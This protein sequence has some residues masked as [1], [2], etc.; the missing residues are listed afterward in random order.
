MRCVPRPLQHG[1]AVLGTAGLLLA[2]WPAGAQV[3]R[4]TDPA[5]GQVSYTNGQCT[6]GQRSQEI[7]PAQSAG[8]IASERRQ[9]QEARERW[10]ASQAK[11]RQAEQASQ[12]AARSQA[13]RTQAPARSESAACRQAQQALQATVRQGSS[14]DADYSWRVDAAQKQVAQLCLDPDTAR[15][16]ERAHSD[17]TRYGIGYGPPYGYPVHPTV[18]PRPP[19][20]PQPVERA[21][22]NVFRCYDKQGNAVPLP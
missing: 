19:V 15:A 1:L 2:A 18:R 20:K 21:R 4:C 14:L 13:S 6:S 11:E 5:T 7:Q 9:A 3:L 22:C 10:D 17:E 12:A 8:D 16:M